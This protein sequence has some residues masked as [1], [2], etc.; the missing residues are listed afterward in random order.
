MNTQLLVKHLRPA[1]SPRR[2]ASHAVHFSYPGWRY[3][4]QLLIYPEEKQDSKVQL[5]SF[6]TLESKL[7]TPSRL[8]HFRAE[9]C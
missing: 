8:E 4:A 7:C 2:A 1:L 3:I 5:F 9:T 6:V